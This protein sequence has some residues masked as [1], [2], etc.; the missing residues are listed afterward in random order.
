MDMLAA[1]A[2]LDD[3]APAA[4]PVRNGRLTD[5]Q[6]WSCVSMHNDH[7]RLEYIADKL[8]VNRNTVAAVIRR[9]KASG[10]P[11][12]GSRSGRPRITDDLTDLH[13]AVTARIDRFTS[14]KQIRRKLNLDCSPDTVERRLHEAGL[15]GRVAQHKRAYSDSE[16][17]KRLA[18][19]NKHKDWTVE[20]WSRI[21]F[22]DEKCFYGK[23]FCGRTWVMRE[24][25]T[26]FD[27]ENCVNKTAHPIKVNVWACFSAAGPGFLYI[28]YEKMD[29]RFYLKILMDNL[30]DVAKRDF[31]AKKPA[32]GEWHFL[33]DNAPMHKA[34][35]VSTWFHNKGV[36]VL[37]FPPYSPDLNPIENLW[38]S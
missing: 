6:R 17:N 33:Q 3:A 19:A 23:G 35:I 7:R 12:S 32:I 11:L 34:K 27:P 14:P 37:D 1:A 2:G 30:C 5:L 24:K 15:F 25:G 8:G 22:S 29:S 31:P 38:R 36:S 10:S 9:A 13:I 26:A 18:F 21:L 20:Q 4:G 28:F 16:R